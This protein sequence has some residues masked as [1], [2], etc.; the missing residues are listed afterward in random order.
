MTSIRLKILT[1]HGFRLKTKPFEFGKK[2][3]Q[4]KAY[5][6]WSRMVQMYVT[7]VAIS[8]DETLKNDLSVSQNA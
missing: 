4:A 1:V 5:L 7:S 3:C 8:S 6:K 2:L